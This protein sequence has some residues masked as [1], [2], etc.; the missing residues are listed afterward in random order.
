[1][2]AIRLRYRPCRA[3][4]WRSSPERVTTTA[5][6]AASYCTPTSLRK[7]CDSLPLGPSTRTVSPCTS[8]LTP[9]GT[10][11]GCF[12]I[13]DMALALKGSPQLAQ[14]LAADLLAAGAAIAHQ[15]AAGAQHRDAQPVQYRP[16]LLVAAILPAAGL[17]DALDVAH[18][19]LALGAVLQVHPQHHV[20]LAERH[21][22]G[23]ELL[24][25]LALGVLADLVVED[26]SL[27][28]QH[29]G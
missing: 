21:A 20:R 23:D 3:L 14:H 7:V 26:V 24:A 12:P 13:R 5:F 10:T 29:A 1:M 11:T 22:L 28:L 19:P 16:Q 4:L 2:L 15:A 6:L 27:V 18:H 8:T 17:A 9:A 25:V